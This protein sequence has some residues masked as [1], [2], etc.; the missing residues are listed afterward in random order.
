MPKREDTT[1]LVLTAAQQSLLC[2][3]LAM[4]PRFEDP[5]HVKFLCD[6]LEALERGDSDRQINVLPP[7]HGK[8]LL[9]SQY[10]PAW[11]LGKHPDHYVISVSYGES[12]TMEWGRKVR[13]LVA[14]PRHQQIFPDCRM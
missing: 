13:N 2:Y 3:A 4:Y 8:T 5:P 6:R 9:G 1:R 10:F 14:D 7:R 11:W 12:L